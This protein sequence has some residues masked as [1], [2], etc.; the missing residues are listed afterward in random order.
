[1]A[2]GRVRAYV[3]MGGNL[4]G[5]VAVSARFAEAAAQ[6]ADLHGVAAVR[7]AS[8]Y[9][10]APVGPVQ[11]QPP[12]LNSAVL[13]LVRGWRPVDFLRELLAIEARAGRDR[14]HE[15][16]LGP[17]PLDLDLLL[18]DDL[19]AEEPGPPPLSLPHPRLSQ[20]AFA[21]APLVELGGDDLLVPGPGGGRAGALLAAALA[22]PAQRVE[23]LG[24]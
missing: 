4:G 10:T 9:R 23:N 18:W 2:Q 14:E 6:I 17:R 15:T 20:R 8:R 11:A 24:A 16:R 12:F 1:M 19:V 22:D 13:V 5:E 3:G 7:R 21:L